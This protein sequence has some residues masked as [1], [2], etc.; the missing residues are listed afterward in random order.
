MYINMGMRIC[1]ALFSEILKKVFEMGDGG[2]GGDFA[3]NFPEV[4]YTEERYFVMEG[5][6]DDFFSDQ[7]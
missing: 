3:S 2:N 5:Y 4:W 1:Q 7:V 6:H